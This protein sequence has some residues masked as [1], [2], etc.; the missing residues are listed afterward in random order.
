MSIIFTIE[1]KL[2]SYHHY[3]HLQKSAR[4]VTW[5]GMEC[6][7]FNII[8]NDSLGVKEKCKM[9]RLLI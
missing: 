4:S 2:L 8:S 7:I 9:E 5:R 1:P 6:K 3:G